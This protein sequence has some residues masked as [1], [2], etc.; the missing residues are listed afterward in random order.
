MS[1]ATTQTVDEIGKIHL[2]GNTVPASWYQQIRTKENKPDFAAITILSD[3]VYWYRPSEIRDEETGRVIG[4]KK[5]F[6]ADKLQR[7]YD[8][9]ADQFGLSKE[10][11]RDACHRLRDAGLM[12]I[13][14]RHGVRYGN[15][16]VANNV[17]YLEPVPSA[18][19]GIS[20]RVTQGGVLK[21]PS[22]P[23]N[24]DTNTLISPNISTATKNKE[25]A[26]APAAVASSVQEDWDAIP[27]ASSAEPVDNGLIPILP[28]EKHLFEALNIERKAQRRTLF[29]RFKTTKQREKFRESI[30]VF[31]GA[32]NRNVDEIIANGKT[33]IDG[34]VNVLDYR[35]R[36]PKQPQRF[37]RPPNRSAPPAPNTTRGI[38]NDEQRKQMLAEHNRLKA[39]STARSP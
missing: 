25:E 28:E 4:Y 1:N 15:S 21:Q 27:S 31:N 12:T 29:V 18:V 8:Q 10:Q 36:N 14:I 3:V 19:L 17:V 2:E 11:A 30:A 13:E 35:R 32:T 34:V 24:V 9:L 6:A 16:G 37:V 7:G 39:L 38:V 5:K 22:P 26:Q 20:Y 33:D 23:S